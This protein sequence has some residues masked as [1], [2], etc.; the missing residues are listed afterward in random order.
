MKKIPI[1]AEAVTVYKPNVR[2]S[3]M[4]LITEAKHVVELVKD[5]WDGLHQYESIKV[6]LLNQANK[7]LGMAAV[8]SGGI[9]MC[10]CDI[11]LLLQKA[12][13]GNA[14]QVILIHNHP[15][16]TPDPSKQ[17]NK[18]TLEV[19]DACKAVAIKLV[20]HLIITGDGEY[21]SYADQTDVLD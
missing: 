15:S 2:T 5:A 3:E 7:V 21:Y 8:S 13:T 14:V 4:P 19:R 16:G 17:D 11:R 12:I 6:L 10:L 18:L 1:L 20:D 9:N